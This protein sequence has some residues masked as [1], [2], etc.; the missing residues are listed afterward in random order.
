M[1]C[2]DVPQSKKCVEEAIEGGKRIS[3]IPVNMIYTTALILAQMTAMLSMTQ[4]RL[5]KSKK[6]VEEAIEGGKRISNI[7]VDMIYTTALILA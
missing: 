6:G 2:V 5:K 3:N 1:G 4:H 7:P